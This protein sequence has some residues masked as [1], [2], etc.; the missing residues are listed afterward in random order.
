MIVPTPPRLADLRAGTQLRAGLGVATVLPDFDFET[1][2]EAGFVWVPEQRRDVGVSWGQDR[3]GGLRVVPAH[4]HVDLGYWT[5]LPGASG[6]RKGLPIV[7]AAAYATHPSTEVLSL[8]YNLKDGQGVRFWRPGEMAP[9]ALFDH[10]ARGGLLEAWNCSFEHW[11]WNYVCTR[12]YGWPRLDVSLLRC[13]MAKSRAHAMPGSLDEAGRVLHLEHQ[14]DPEGMRLIK[15]FAMPRDPTQTDPRTRLD[16]ATDPEGQKLYAYNVRDI[17]A[18]AE[19]SSRLPD[20]SPFE[21]E[22]WQCE[23]RINHRGVAIDTKALADCIYVVEAALKAFNAE[24]HTLTGGIKSTEVQKL[25]G[26]LHAIGVHLDGLAEEDIEH[27]LA[28]PNIQG[29]ARR[30]LEIRALAASASVK[31]LFAIR[32]QLSPWGRLHD[33]FTY[34]GS[35][36]GRETAQ[37]PQPQNLVKHGPPVR[38]CQTCKHHYGATPLDV[39]QWCGAIDQGRTVEWGPAAAIDALAVVATR[40]LDTIRR[41]FGDI[42]ATVAGCLRALFIAG[43]GH[44]FISSDYSAI[45]GVVAAALSGCQWRLDVYRTTGQIY[46]ESAS[47]AFGVS[48]SEMLQHKTETGMHHPLRD[49]GKRMELGLGFGGWVGA[50]RSDQIDYQGTDDELKAAI[51]AWRAASPELPEMWGGQARNWKPELYGLEG[52]A[53][54]AIMNPGQTYT[55]R[56]ISYVV[57]G[58]VLYCRLPSGRHITYHA[59]RLEPQ[60]DPSRKGFAISYEGW[61]TNPKAGGIGWVRMYIYGGKFFEN[62]VQAVA[63]DILVWAIVHLERAR[64]SVVLHVH[65]EI[66]SQVRKN[67]RTLAEFESIL[68]SLPPFAKGWPI[69]ARGGYVDD[70]F[71]KAS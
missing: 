34:H 35:K 1:Y 39:C 37:G 23:Q 43:P 67:S 53:V 33:L 55:Y 36:T 10:A 25:L 45:E 26:W 16:P 20:L 49:K 7:Q 31:K 70:R 12:R 42:L 8:A 65:D 18:E 19:A 62:V 66:V 4:T 63:R 69:F 21:L 44:E 71:C 51:L 13:A 52:M 54:A 41:V 56:E 22:Y 59:P 32:N 60:S 3:K 47:R 11:I 46:I 50:L 9:Q 58:D 15:R 38:Q 14:K 2:S 28:D 61:N 27:A 24:L 57:R 29:A 5:G 6:N 17:E 64:L 68:C 40:N 48:V 30:V